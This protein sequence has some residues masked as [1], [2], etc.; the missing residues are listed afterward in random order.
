MIHNIDTFDYKNEYKNEQN[1]I[2][3]EV[4]HVLDDIISQVICKHNYV[5][6]ESNFSIFR[7]LIQRKFNITTLIPLKSYEIN[8]YIIICTLLNNIYNH[9]LVKQID[10]ISRDRLHS[11]FLQIYKRSIFCKSSKTFYMKLL[12]QNI[13]PIKYRNVVIMEYINMFINYLHNQI[14][15]IN[16]LIRNRQLLEAI[17]KSTLDYFICKIIFISTIIIKFT[18]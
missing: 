1:S 12:L 18:Q 6:I 4:S 8:R 7:Q 9:I 13:E 17:D 3:F 16:K 10:K 15:F 2:E 11:M 5:F 14:A